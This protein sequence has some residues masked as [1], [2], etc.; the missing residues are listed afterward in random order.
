MIS[1]LLTIWGTVHK[2]LEWTNI[3][4][5]YYSLYEEVSPEGWTEWPNWPPTP[6]YHDMWAWR[7]GVLMTATQTAALG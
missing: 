6:L 3:R 5:A 1:Q 4:I 2:H 7:H